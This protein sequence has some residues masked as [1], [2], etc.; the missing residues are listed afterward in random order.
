MKTIGQKM[1]DDL[2]LR[3]MSRN[4]SETY[5]RYARHF[6]AFTSKPPGRAGVDEVRAFL[7]HLRGDRK[8]CA[9]SVNVAIAALRF[10]FDVTLER[11]D[12]MGRVRNLREVHTQPVILSADELRA[13]LAAMSDS[14]HRA[15]ALL[16]YGSGLRVTEAVSLRVEDLDTV[17]A[18]IRVRECKNRRERIVPL[19]AV[20][21]AALREYARERR[22]RG[23]LLFPGRAEGKH[24]TREAVQVAMRNAARRAGVRKRVYPHLLRHAFATHML[25]LQA[26]LRTV[27]ILLGHQNIQSTARYT[28]LSEARRR[29]LPSPVEVLFSSEAPRLG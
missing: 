20:T 23:P 16:L 1:S 11:P 17:R 9:R 18:V 22:V 15:I 14:R 4:T 2:T 28:H 5:L 21:L 7:L 3:G 12:V 8:L 24:F 6:A 27:Q 29:N 25:E 10:L 13:V 19:P 26:D